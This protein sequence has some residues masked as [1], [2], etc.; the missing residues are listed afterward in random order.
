M[1]ILFCKTGWMNFYDGL[2]C[3]ASFIKEYGTEGEIYNFSESLS[4]YYGF[5][6]SEEQLRIEKL[7]ASAADDYIDNVLVVIQSYLVLRITPVRKTFGQKLL[8]FHQK[9]II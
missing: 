4:K 8:Y 6:M 9:M 3:G 2:A 1:T 5:V 7:G